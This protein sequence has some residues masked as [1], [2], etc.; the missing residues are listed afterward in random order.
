[1]EM[2]PRENAVSE[3]KPG[4]NFISSTSTFFFSEDKPTL[5]LRTLIGVPSRRAQLNNFFFLFYYL[6]NSRKFDHTERVTARQQQNRGQGKKTHFRHRKDGV[7]LPSFLLSSGANKNYSNA[8]CS[9]SVDEKAK[10]KAALDS[11]GECQMP[12]EANRAT[13]RLPVL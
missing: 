8:T 3:E 2:K 7:S 6:G 9:G 11:K 1:M 12:L 13:Q 5:V 10:R 4:R